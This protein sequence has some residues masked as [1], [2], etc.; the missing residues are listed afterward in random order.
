MLV[1]EVT[2]CKLLGLLKAT[3]QN[4]KLWV[5]MWEGRIGHCVCIYMYVCSGQAQNVVS[6]ILNYCKDL[7]V[8]YSFNLLP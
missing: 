5:K 4:N 8:R 6:S 1:F 2:F 3:E 7:Q